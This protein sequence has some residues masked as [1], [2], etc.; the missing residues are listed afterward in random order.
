MSNPG[1][2]HFIWSWESWKSCCPA[3]RG[4][5]KPYKSHLEFPPPL[6]PDQFFMGNI[7]C[8]I[9]FFYFPNKKTENFDFF[10]NLGGK[11]TARP[12]FNL[13]LRPNYPRISIQMHKTNFVAL[14]LRIIN[15]YEFGSHF[16]ATVPGSEDFHLHCGWLR[17]SAEPSPA[18][19]ILRKGRKLKI[20]TILIKS[21]HP[22]PPGK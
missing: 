7:F 8:F 1:C 12:I 2:A 4:L 5:L 20:I 22:Q 19:E 18:N 6:H 13:N 14:V 15:P 3:F 9:H 21:W 17:D 11:F 10:E 16:A